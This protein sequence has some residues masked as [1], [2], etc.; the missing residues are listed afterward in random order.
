MFQEFQVSVTPVDRDRYLV[1]TEKVAPGVPLAEE[2]VR[3]SVE[4][5]LE[6]AQQLMND[7]LLGV[8]QSNGPLLI[9]GSPRPSEDVPLSLIALGQK[10][11]DALFQGSLRDSWITAQGIAHYQRSLLRLRL[12]LK[13]NLLPRLPWEVLHTGGRESPSA[14]YRPLATG[15]DIAFSR[16]QM[17]ALA[18][19]PAIAFAKVKDRPVR[20]LMAIAGPDDRE[21]LDLQ[22]EAEDLKAELASSIDRAAPAIEVTILPHP[23]REELTRALEQG[24]YHVFHYAG[25]SNF[26]DS[27]GDIYLVNNTTGL[28]ETVS[29]ED[30][31]GLL[32]NNGVQLAVFNSCRG[33]DTAR[34]IGGTAQGERNLAQALVKCGIPAV[35]AMAER[36]P[37]DVAKTLTRLFY[38]NLNQGYPIDLSLSRARQGLIASYGSNQ[39]YW[40]LPVLYL[41][42]KFDGMLMELDEESDWVEELLEL[43]EADEIPLEVL[44]GEGRLGLTN[45]LEEGDEDDFLAPVSQLKT[46]NGQYP[47]GEDADAIADEEDFIRDL[48]NDLGQ[49]ESPVRMFEETATPSPPVDR[50]PTPSPEKPTEEQVK[51]APPKRSRSKGKWGWLVW[52]FGG[53]GLGAIA[54]AGWWFFFERNLT[55]QMPL[56]GQIPTENVQPRSTNNVDFA[57][58][59]TETL[60]GIATE[61]FIQG[62]FEQGKLAVEEL[63]DPKRNALQNAKAALAAVP[64]DKQDDPAILFLRGRLAWQLALGG[65]KDFS[66]DDARRYW[67]SAV[68]KDPNSLVYHNA[69][70]FAYYE[71]G[72]FNRAN[73]AWSDALE[74][75]PKETASQDKQVLNTYAGLALALRQMA[76]N[77][78]ENNQRTLINKAIK[79][80]QLVISE[81]PV[82]FQS[83]ALS[84][85][86]LWSEKAIQDW[87]GLIAARES[88]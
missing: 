86:W 14:C 34:A 19:N 67:E 11:Y 31:A 30:L 76:K 7:P 47:I 5:W 60:T 59:Q 25:H 9:S 61:Q 68:K 81:D 32:A 58:V 20:I 13:G 87:Q 63:L 4:E 57:Q 18:G 33:A 35:L 23:G 10:L 56:N 65:N 62:N 66:I 12:G 71:E 82:N 3:W 22:Q 84:S 74:L 75:S 51:T 52:V 77:Q 73:Q 1:R 28:T 80:R 45:A 16:Y 2:Q 29:G 37:D 38:R 49:S 41:H 79:L 72:D 43:S 36:I 88:Q 55:P 39:L 21:G 78:P 17:N 53:V 70:G 27:G 69:L 54:L 50:P 42:P 8:F 64:A 83:A 85:N 44:A 48:M 46:N 15:T 24:Q 26:G 40:A 6:E